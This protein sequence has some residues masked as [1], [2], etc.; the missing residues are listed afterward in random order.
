MHDPDQVFGLLGL[1]E[2]DRFLDLGCGPGDYSI[3]ACREVG[4][5]GRVTA[6][7][8]EQEAMVQIKEKILSQGCTNI[9]VIKADL[10]QPLPLETGIVDLCLLATV[11]HIHR[12]REAGPALFGEIRRVL[13]PGGRLAVIECKKEEQDFGPPLHLRLAPEEVEEAVA[14]L[15]FRR[16]GY[17]DLGYN[18]LILFTVGG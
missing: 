7:D 5:S 15:G 2:G 4:P 9:R 12:I 18:Y 17:A 1:K 14:P 3:R 6:L 8:R 13:G 16:S 11:L 10:S